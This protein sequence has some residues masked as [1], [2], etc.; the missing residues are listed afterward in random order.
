MSKSSD[1][2]SLLS[3]LDV[4]A[5]LHSLPDAVALTTSEAAVFLRSSVSALESMRS[6]GIGP[7]YI[8]GG[9]RGAVGSNQK[10]LYEKGDL[11]DWMRANKVSS[12]VE[13]AVRKGQLFM[14]VADIAREEAFWLDGQGQV[15]GMVEATLVDTVIERLGAYEIAWLPVVDA[16]ARAW[17]DLANH[18][19][20]ADAV[21]N[22]LRKELLRAQAGVEASEIA[23]EARSPEARR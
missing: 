15:V 6:K 19:A 17:S 2:N 20:L 1:S 21:S 14:S 9:G 7:A 23:S 10:C 5:R 8:Q 22:V 16:A 18:K 3:H 11:L 4:L 13:A 12:T